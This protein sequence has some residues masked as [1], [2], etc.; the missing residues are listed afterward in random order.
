MMRLRPIMRNH[1]EPCGIC[2]IMRNLRPI[3]RN[4]AESCRIIMRNLRPVCKTMRNHD[5]EPAT[6]H[7]RYI[8]MQDMF[9]HDGAPRCYESERASSLWGGVAG[10]ASGGVQEGVRR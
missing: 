10:S 7:G 6:N 2:G 9:L 4:H 8:F 3:M 1:A 5:A